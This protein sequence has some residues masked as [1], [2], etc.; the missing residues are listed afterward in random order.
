MNDGIYLP[1]SEGRFELFKNGILRLRQAVADRG[2]QIIHL[3]PPTF[4]PAGFKSQ[5]QTPF[6]Y[7][8][9]LDRYSDWLLDQRTRVDRAGPSRPDE[10]PPRRAS[11]TRPFLPSGGDGVHPNETGHWL[12]ARPL[13]VYFGAPADFATMESVKPMLN[14]HSNGPEILKLVQQR[15]RLLKDAWLS[16]TGHKRPE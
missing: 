1:L 3:T 10:S 7:N 2:A 14:L 8:Q 16:E 5:T 6:N 12:M 9:V 4:D 13:L 15:Q 11:S